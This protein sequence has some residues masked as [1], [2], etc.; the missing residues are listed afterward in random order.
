M[1]YSVNTSVELGRWGGGGASGKMFLT[2]VVIMP[3]LPSSPLCSF[4]VC[5]YLMYKECRCFSLDFFVFGF[6]RI[7]S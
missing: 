2:A 5:A 3:A 1:V 7:A 6:T 4:F